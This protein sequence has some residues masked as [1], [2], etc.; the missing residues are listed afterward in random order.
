MS[1]NQ[2]ADFERYV[3]RCDTLRQ[4]ERDRF[5]DLLNNKIPLAR[6]GIVAPP[7]TTFEVRRQ[8]IEGLFFRDSLARWRE[9]HS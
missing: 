6:K 7:S 8:E 3:A 1:S 4:V 2:F 9:E 5:E